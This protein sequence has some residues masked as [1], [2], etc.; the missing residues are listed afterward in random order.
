LGSYPFGMDAS[1]SL[2][3]TPDLAPRGTVNMIVPD[4]YPAYLVYS[5]E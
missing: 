2:H 5:C 3:P 1:G 4:S